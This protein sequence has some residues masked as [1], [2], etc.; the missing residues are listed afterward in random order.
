LRTTTKKGCQLFDEKK[1]TP[2]KILAT[3]IG[4]I[5]KDSIGPGLKKIGKSWWKCISA[6]PTETSS[7]AIAK[8][9]RCRMA[10]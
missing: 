4:R 8:R 5:E 6:V 10:V 7:S 3:S 9:P 2:E 1:C